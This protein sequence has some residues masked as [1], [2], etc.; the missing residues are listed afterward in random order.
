MKAFSCSRFSRTALAAALLAA[1]CSGSNSP[2]QP[3][4]NTPPTTVTPPTTTPPTTTPPTT[5]PTTPPTG[6]TNV[7]FNTQ[8]N[9]N[10]AFSGQYPSGTIDWGTNRWYLSSPFGSFTTNSVGFNGAGPASAPFTFVTPRRLVTVDAFNGG[11]TSS[12]I[13]LSC[14]GQ[15]TVTAVLAANALTTITTNWTQPCTTVTVGSTNGWNTNFDNF[16]IQ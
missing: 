14:A 16:I 12:T 8:T 5:S 3:P 10:R 2:T 13:T 11:T 15:P 4:V 9:P 1:A 7:N 6:T